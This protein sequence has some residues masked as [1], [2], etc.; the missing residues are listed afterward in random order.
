MTKRYSIAEARAG[1]PMIVDEVESGHDI[2]LT[3][4]GKPVAILMSPHRYERLRS[5]RPPFREVYE[6]FLR[7]FPLDEIGL[8]P[9]A[10]GDVR[11]RDAG[12]S[13]AL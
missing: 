12:R 11:G 6:A 10:F 1:L 5:E 9:G 13:V 2:E 8:D 3:R 4:R 7:R